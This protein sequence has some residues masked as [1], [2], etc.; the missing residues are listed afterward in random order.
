[1]TETRGERAPATASLRRGLAVA[2]LVVVSIEGMVWTF[3]R[4]FI[5]NFDVAGPNATI[6]LFLLLATGWS[7]AVVART[8]IGVARLFYAATAA[9]VL[10]F[11]GSLAADPL[12][13]GL[14]AVVMVT[15]AT[16]PLVALLADLES[17]V[18]V[19]VGLGILLAGAL[20]V[21]LVTASP[22][23]TTAGTLLFAL[24][25]GGAGVHLVALGVRDQHPSVDWQAVGMAPA[26]LGTFLV[27]AAGFLAHPQAVARWGLQSYPVAVGAL[28]VG[29]WVGL[30]VVHL[31]PVPTGREPALWAAVFLGAVVSMLYSSGPVALGAFAVV[32]VSALV[33]LAVGARQTGTGRG[34]LALTGFQTL[35]LLVLFF[36]ITA[37]HWAFVPAPLSM[38]AGLGTELTVLFLAIFPL[39]VAVAVFDTAP[40]PS[41][42]V[43]QSRRSALSAVAMGLLAPV[44]LAATQS[45]TDAALPDRQAGRIRVMTYNLH[46]FFEEEP[47]GQYSLTALRDVIA[48]AEPDIVAVSESD[49]LRPLPGYVDG[50]RWLGTELGY[51]TEFGGATRRRSYGVGL[52]SRWPI[53]DVSV[54]EL[55]IGRSLT[56]LAVTATVE[57]PQGPLPVLSTHFMVGKE[58]DAADTR[59]EQA[60][61][62]TDWAQG[63]DQALVMGDFNVSPDEPEYDI[64]TETLEDAW[65]ATESSRRSGPAGTYSASDPRDRIDYIFMQGDWT[66]RGIETIA[67]PDASD[68]LA[69]VADL[70]RGD[71]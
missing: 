60:R 15:A 46:L 33:L 8:G 24:V 49:G 31:R 22:Y 35:A 69:V 17:R 9:L 42:P 36:S 20:R 62:V 64:L 52:L 56:R 41:T 6:M 26:V 16:P 28:V 13:A 10:G 40:S 4:I 66:V 65:T 59:D 45:D 3:T 19:G 14:G 61:T 39:S 70:D 32:W 11:A 71:E 1:M 25:V 44:T 27:V 30:A 2:L 63:H 5:L 21:T 58:D 67:D 55:P 34:A 7:L 47:S 29:V 53:T 57:T 50:L 43:R 12:V 23:A 68:H 18:V 38:L 54:I 51:H 37:T 48:D